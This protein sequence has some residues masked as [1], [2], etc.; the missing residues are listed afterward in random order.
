M[1]IDI[2]QAEA[3]IP[4]GCADEQKVVAALEAI[5]QTLALKEVQP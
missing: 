3:L 4:E 2:R 1:N 5:E